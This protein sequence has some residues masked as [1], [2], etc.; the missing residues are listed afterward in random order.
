MTNTIAFIFASA[1]E[2]NP[3]RVL[4]DY[5]KKIGSYDTLFLCSKEKE[6]ILKKDVDLDF[7]ELEKYQIVCP[8]GAESL[9]YVCGLTGITKYNGVFVE[10]RYVPVIHPNLTVFK[11]QYQ[12]DIKKAFSTI[13]KVINGIIKQLELK[14]NVS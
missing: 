5:D 7:K 2:K 10:K 4:S 1:S 13:E 8:V 11:P 6:K 9:K 12:D 3:A 14:E